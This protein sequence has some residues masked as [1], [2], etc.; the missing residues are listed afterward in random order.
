[1]STADPFAVFPADVFV[2]IVL[3]ADTSN[4]VQVSKIFWLL[5]TAVNHKSAAFAS[6]KV[7]YYRAVDCKAGT[8]II[9]RAIYEAALKAR[10]Y[11]LLPV[12]T[13]INWLM[14]VKCNRCGYT[15]STTE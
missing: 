2:L 6:L 7:V 11:F 13:Q 8:I 1:M 4:G 3:D 14:R 9:Y 12:A 5:E 15:R 10:H